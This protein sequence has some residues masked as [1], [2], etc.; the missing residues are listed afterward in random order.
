MS[1]QLSGSLAPT[2]QEP[3]SPSLNQG[4]EGARKRLDKYKCIFLD[5]FI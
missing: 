5:I 1:W 2:R 3:G 4:G